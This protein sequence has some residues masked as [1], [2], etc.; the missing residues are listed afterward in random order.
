MGHLLG[1]V[2]FVVIVHVLIGGG[3]PAVLGL[4]IAGWAGFIVAKHAKAFWV[5]F[6][7]NPNN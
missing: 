4:I 1:L 2:V 3:A 5:W 6:N 7:Y